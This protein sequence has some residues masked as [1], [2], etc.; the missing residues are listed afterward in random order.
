[1]KRF[2]CLCILI[3]FITL[4]SCDVQE[5]QE[6]ELMCG[7][8]V[9]TTRNLDFPS[10]PGLSDA[11]L[12]KEIRDICV[13]CSDLGVNTIYL[14]VRANA[15]ALY[16]DSIFGPS[17]AIY[18]SRKENDAVSIDILDRFIENAHEYGIRLY[19]WVNPYRIDSGQAEEIL[20]S[21]PSNHPAVLYPYTAMPY[22]GGV[23]FDPGVPKTREIIITGVQEIVDRYAVDGIVFDD[24]FYPYDGGYDDSNTFQT[25]GSNFSNVEDFR[26]Y[27]VN[28]LIQDCSALLKEKDIEFG[29]SPFGIW[30]NQKND[31]DGSKTA[32][33][34]AYREIFADSKAWVENE[35]IDFIAPQLYWSIG[36]EQADFTELLSWWSALCDDS[37][38]KL[39]ISHYISRIGSG[40]KGWEDSGQIDRQLEL[41]FEQKVYA[42][43]IFFRYGDFVQ[44]EYNECAVI[45]KYYGEFSM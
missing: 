38:V 11:E 36:N 9:S 40:L 39:Y 5:N 29:I 31:A 37:N 19:A 21:L 24:Y 13:K 43:S 34:S 4:T 20:Q 45:S 23:A 10:K 6:K 22:G 7:M 35:W 44:N 17:A 18:G 28:R 12:E 15:D 1:M 41:C 30:S 27:S 8:W 26:R 2:V 25:Y 16:K 14:Q 33:L 42:G 32:G 3:L